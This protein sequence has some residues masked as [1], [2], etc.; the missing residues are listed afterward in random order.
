M[1]SIVYWCKSASPTGERQSLAATRDGDMTRGSGLGRSAAIAS[2]ALLCALLVLSPLTPAEAAAPHVSAGP[3]PDTCAMCHRAH[4]GPGDFGRIDDGSWE[5]TSSALGMAVPS[6]AGDTSLCY[7]CHGIDALGSGTPVGESFAK[8]SVHSLAPIASPFGPSVKYCSSCHDSHGNDKVSPGVPFPDLLRSRAADGSP[9]FQGSAYC[10]TC[11]AVRPASRFPGVSLYEKTAHYAALPD[12]ANGTAVRCSVCHAGHGSDVAPLM[13]SRITPPSVTATEAVTAN[14]RTFCLVCHPDARATYPGEIDYAESSHALSEATTTVPGEWPAPGASRLVGECQAC[15]APMGRDDGTGEPIPTLLEKK[16]TELCLTCHDLDGPAATDLAALTYPVA[17]AGDL[18]LVAAF[19]PETTTAAFG[20]V[21]VWGTEA[22]APA[23]RSIVGPRFYAP[24]GTSGVTVVGDVD[25]DGAPNVVTADR[26]SA[27]V[28]VFSPDALKGL[29]YTSSADVAAIDGIATDMVIANVVGDDTPELCIIAGDTLYL[30]RYDML[31]VIQLDTVPAIGTDLTGLAAG[32][33]DGDGTAELV[34][35]D[36]G[37]PAI[38]VLTESSVTPGTLSPFI[39]P[40]AAKAGV[41]GPSVG[42]IDDANGIEIAVANAEDGTDSVTVYDAGGSEIASADLPGAGSAKAWDTLI[43]DVLPGSTPAGTSGDELSVV[44]N[45]AEGT[46]SI[47]IFG[48]LTG[49]GLAAPESHGTGAGA[50]SGSLAAGDID[51]DG[52]AELVVGNGGFWSRDASL[53]TPP[54]VLVLE[55][56]ALQTAFSSSITL[57]AGGIER[58]GAAPSLAIADL[59]PVGPSRHPVAAVADSHTATETA[60]FVR[61]VECVDCH[62]SH[63]A[64]S[65]VAVAPAAYGRIKGVYG[66]TA[67]YANAQPINN[68]YE[69]CYK[70]HSAYQNAAGLDGSK[71]IAALVDPGN[72]SVHAI[73]AA[74]GTSINEE[75]FEAGW[76]NTKVLYCVDC[77]SAAGAS[78]AVSGPHASSESPILRSPYLGA[79]PGNAEG[80]C[81][82]CHK[83]SVYYTGSDDTTITTGSFFWDATAG[84]LHTLHVADQGFGCESCHDSHGSPTNERLVREDISYDS[85]ARSCTDSCH[86]GGITY[87]P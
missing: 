71:D 59:G 64:T 83:Y 25:G 51:G 69:L 48:Q 82:D 55:H 10:G 32:D 3:T 49:G 28:T 13:A 1:R 6:G 38:H 9:V 17:S 68:E 8:T 16:P 54:S 47:H 41:R 19:S 14:D 7:V 43:A 87:T 24:E 29:A 74:A 22:A 40:I 45:G 65:T 77:H 12:P 76:D 50:G 11:H 20:T 61:H 31:G 27:Q 53:A 46:S 63:E 36:A 80:L 67:A 75:T 60:P 30:Y 78:P 57:T 2:A 58:S 5:M 18:E 85:A 23:P 37:A 79:R 81:Y 66:A 72:P 44:A 62:N 39:A 42:D 86:P 84:A 34:V 26:S 35:T 15:H 33:L 70:C 73:E 56:N 4:S 52:A 21:A